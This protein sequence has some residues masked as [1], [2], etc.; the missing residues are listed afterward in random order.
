MILN[1]AF[2]F[3]LSTNF[4]RVSNMDKVQISKS[5]LVEIKEKLEKSNTVNAQLISRI[6]TLE[7]QLAKPIKPQPQKDDSHYSAKIIELKHQLG[8]NSN[9]IHSMYRQKIN[10]LEMDLLKEKIKNKE[11]E[12]R[13]G[14]L[15]SEN[16]QMKEKVKQVLCKS[17]KTCEYF[18]DNRDLQQTEMGGIMS[19]INQL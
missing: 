6:H 5:S 10:Q 13:V 1:K 19:V 7:Q 8:K 16:H 14:L 4:L 2:H 18:R 9:E 15:A 11:L 3:A 12:T 17:L